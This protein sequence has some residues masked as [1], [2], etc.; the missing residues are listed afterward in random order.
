MTHVLAYPRCAV[1]NTLGVHFPVVR[2]EAKDST[3]RE[4][5]LK[6]RLVVLETSG[7]SDRVAWNLTVVTEVKDPRDPCST[8]LS[9]FSK[10]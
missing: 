5:G 10:V 9:P 2:G 3:H 8:T 1:M 6:S 7:G 4:R